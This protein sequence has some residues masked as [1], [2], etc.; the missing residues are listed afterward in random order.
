MATAMMYAQKA[1][2]LAAA[3]AE[4]HLAVGMLQRDYDSAA[5]VKHFQE[6]L[7]LKVDHPRRL[8]ILSWIEDAG[9]RQMEE[10][11]G[12]IASTVETQLFHKEERSGKKG[13]GS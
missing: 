4:V 5:A 3:N 12:T 10:Q 6:V 8:E 13:C 9:Q 11:S 2:S 7:R 1:V